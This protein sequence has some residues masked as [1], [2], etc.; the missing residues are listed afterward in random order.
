VSTK[1]TGVSDWLFVRRVLIVLAIGVLALALWTLSDLLLLVFAAVLC[2]VALRALMAPLVEATGMR[3]VFALAC[4]VLLIVLFAAAL[5]L[6]FGSR[7]SDQTTYLVQ[8]APAAFQALV[9]MLGLDL[10]A[11]SRDFAGTAIGAIAARAVT[12]GSGII[13]A[14][15]AF[16]LI[17]V[18]GIYLAAAPQT[19]RHGLIAV[20]PERWRGQVTSTVNDSAFALSRWLRAQLIAMAIV[21][22]MTGLGMWLVG[23][24]SPL[25]LGLIAGVTEFIPIVGPIVGA[26]PALLLASTLGWEVT[27]AA[28]A[29]AIVVQQL[30]NNLIMPFVVGRVVELPAAVGLFAT[31]AMGLLF[32]P[33][34]LLLGYPLAI[35]ADVAIRRLYVREALG[36]PVEI[37]AERER[38]AEA[39]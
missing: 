34:G 10:N 21:G 1:Q 6:Q 29:V 14:V 17:A 27:L 24:P 38:H 4:V 26:I 36:K 2:A 32:G 9:Q 8:N 18:G 13:E 20:F 22:A 31:V 33:L 15:A 28:L 39:K 30:E 19:Y 25:A 3:E 7:L 12:I 23:V 37:P 16:V 11:L 5:V 35:V